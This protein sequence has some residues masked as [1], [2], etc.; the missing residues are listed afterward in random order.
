MIEVLRKANR[1][2]L[3]GA[4]DRILQIGRTHAERRALGRPAPGLTLGDHDRLLEQARARPPLLPALADIAATVRL[5]RERFPAAVAATLAAAERSCAHRFTLFGWLEADA[6][7]EI[8]WLREPTTGIVC[9]LDFWAG[10]ALEDSHLGNLR[11]LWELNRHQHL[12]D[13]ARALCFTGDHRFADEI[14]RQLASWVSQN[15]RGLGVNWASSLEVALRAVAWLWAR[16]LL[17]ASDGLTP[18]LNAEFL[19]ALQASGTHI[20]R[21]LSHTY[22]PNTH[23]LGEALGLIYLGALVPELAAARRWFALGRRILIREARYQVLDD[24]FHFEHSTWYHRFATDLYLHAAVLCER[25]GA[26]FPAPTRETIFQMLDCLAALG[27]RTNE[28]ALIGDDDG[29]QALPLAHLPPG[30]FRDTMAVGAALF[31]RGDYKPEGDEPAE[32][33]LWLL[34]PEGLAAYDS[35]QASAPA[36]ESYPRLSAA[37]VTIMRLP[38]GHSLAFDY[39]DFAAP[40]SA[41][42]HA[43]AL[44]IQIRSQSGPM[45]IDAGTYTYA[46]PA[47]RSY[48]RGTGAHN[49]LVLDGGNQ[50]QERGPFAWAAPC[51]ADY[52]G[53][54][55]QHDFKQD[56]A[57]CRWRSGAV[58]W[59]RVVQVK[60]RYWI[61]VD[62]VSGSGTHL[63]EQWFHF[64]P[65]QAA[66]D[67]EGRCLAHTP[68]GPLWVVPGLPC[69]ARLVEG[70]APDARP[71]GWPAPPP[72]AGEGRV[73][74]KMGAMRPGSPPP[75]SSPI[76]GE[77][78]QGWVSD[79]FGRKQPAPALCYRV[80]AALPVT[81]VAVI[82]PSADESPSISRVGTSDSGGVGLE[83]RVD[84]A[85]HHLDVPQPL[86]L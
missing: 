7:A 69:E 72:S 8:N 34:G 1:A 39:G 24:G 67:A 66:L 22:S 9:P 60:R 49:T 6:G 25:A 83:I 70:Q 17:L 32:A 42:G 50:A 41:H 28:T 18:P 75:Q 55:Q 45:L 81:L 86:S 46:D 54:T 58:H 52:L 62:V 77:V 29:G 38:T 44:A 13:L 33:A 30:D 2:G 35:L 5:A 64:P 61:I 56:E 82:V 48:F 71:A 4:A 68:G 73:G 37:G 43:G 51:K 27:A 65:C 11:A 23:L 15:P 76:K 59:R 20:A 36:G 79:A 84:G 80:S 14:A 78:P 31:Q 63:L 47:W 57:E 26:P 19:A 53:W 85:S 12:L 40:D 10:I 74:G 21:H 3:A 16:A